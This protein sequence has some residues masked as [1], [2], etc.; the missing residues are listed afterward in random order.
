MGL[1]LRGEGAALSVRTRRAATV[2]KS[3]SISAGD[4]ADR[5]GLPR[6]GWTGCRYSA[7]STAGVNME[8]GGASPAIRT[9]LGARPV[10]RLKAR[11]NEASDS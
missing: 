6:L 5:H 3:V 10:M 9:W 1:V 2:V 11:L 8:P 7:A 4:G